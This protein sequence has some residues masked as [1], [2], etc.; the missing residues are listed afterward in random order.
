MKQRSSGA[1]DR[2]FKL[3]T[4]GAALIVL[5]LTGMILYQRLPVL[6]SIKAYGLGF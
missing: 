1:V 6:T 4:T 2:I 3:L 5:A